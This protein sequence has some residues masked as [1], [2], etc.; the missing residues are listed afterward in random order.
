MYLIDMWQA[1]E[2]VDIIQFYP[3]IGF[4]ARF[5]QGA[6]VGAFIV[7]HKTA[8]QCPQAVARFNGAFTQ[9]D[10]ILM[11]GEST[12]HNEWILIMDVA[13]GTTD[14]AL[15]VITGRHNQGQLF[16]TL[17]TVMHIKTECSGK[18]RRP[19]NVAKYVRS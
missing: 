15:P 9:Q 13:A 3:G 2:A 18:L 14:M 16:S 5:P 1:V 11:T 19:D 6:L 4:F 17:G 12:D 7:F 10:L 8:W